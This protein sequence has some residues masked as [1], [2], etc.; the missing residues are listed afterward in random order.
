MSNKSAITPTRA[1]NYAE[2]YQQVIKGADMADNSGVRGCM[3]IKPWG[4]GIWELLVR[5]LDERFKATGHENCYFPLFIPLSLIQKEAEHAEGF[6]KEMAVVTHHR[7]VSRDGKLVPDGELEEPLIVRPTSETIIG[8][9]FAKWIQS[10]RDL[11]VLIN[12]WANV[13]RWEMRPRI[14]LRTAEFLWQEGHTAHADKDDAMREVMQMLEV[15]RDVAESVLALPVIA[16]EKTPHER[17]AG[18]VNTFTIEAMMQDGKALQAGTSHYLGQ[19]FSKAAGIKFQSKEGREEF[20]HTTSWGVSTRMIGAIIMAHADD[21]GLRLP[22][23]VAPQQV[24]IVPIIREGADNDAVLRYAN[25]LATALRGQHFASRP[26]RAKVDTRDMASA[27]KRWS[28]I[29]KGVPLIC[30]V[31]PKDLEKRSVAITWRDQLGAGKA[32]VPFD[33]LANGAAA[34]LQQYEQRLFDAAAAI[35]TARLR[36]DITTLADFKAYFAESGDK[37]FTTGTGFVQAPFCGDEDAVEGVLKE[38]GVTIRCMPLDSKAGGA[39][40]FTGKPATCTA[41]FARAY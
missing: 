21:D 12:Q 2:W 1:E 18:A 32:F 27:E 29:K 8:E 4:Y 35:R 17:F 11:P 41:I 19:N 9:A 13:V 31:G 36:T 3:I 23:K 22:P 5:E 14:F 10:Y 15:Y 20:V 38:M 37:G 7:L 39:C 16:G 25:E 33:E 34:Q 30:E 26:V 28:W 6:A 24:V 40:I